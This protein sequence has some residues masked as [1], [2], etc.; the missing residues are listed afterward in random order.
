MTIAEGVATILLFGVN[1]V[2]LCTLFSRFRGYRVDAL[3]H[4]LFVLRDEL[5]NHALSSELSFGNPAYIVLRRRINRMLRFA[6]RIS[7]ARVLFT[8]AFLPHDLS[9]E[10]LA[11]NEREWDDALGQL[12]SEEQQKKISELHEKL[13]WEVAKHMIIGA[14]PLLLLLLQVYILQRLV[15]RCEKFLLRKASIVEVEAAYAAS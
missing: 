10:M 2:L 11:E 3:R 15:Q 5:F 9:R 8:V 12:D 13:L 14:T 6:H 1:L 4:R 7:F